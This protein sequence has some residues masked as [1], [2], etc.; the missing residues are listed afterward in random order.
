MSAGCYLLI[1][2]GAGTMDILCY[3]T[4]AEVH[5]KAVVQ[6]PVRQ[7]AQT[8]E[9]AGCLCCTVERIATGREPDAIGRQPAVVLSD[10]CCDGWMPCSISTLCPHY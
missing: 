10:H 2:V 7:L 5:Y 8:I 9:T 6:S 1:D 4:K 3:D